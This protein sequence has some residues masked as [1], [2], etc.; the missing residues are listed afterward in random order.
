VSRSIP[1]VVVATRIYL[2]EPAAASFRLGAVVGRLA[3]EG[4]R[5]VVLTTRARGGAAPPRDEPGDV[6]R[7]PALRDRSGYVRGYL[8]YLSFDLPL[9]LRLLCSARPGVVL[10]EPPPT[11][12]AVVRVV[13]ALR[14]VPYVYFAPDIWSDAA[15]SAGAGRAVVRVLRAVERWVA[16][17]AARVV[18]VSDDLAARLR[19][20]APT[21]RVEVV[22]NGVDTAVFTLS[23][24]VAP[25]APDGAYAVYAGTT[26]EWQGAD[27]FLRAFAVVRERMPGARLVLVGQG[28]AWRELQRL[29]AEL[30][31]AGA[32]RFVDTR[33]APEAAAWLR[34]A[35]VSLVGI[36]PG[37]GY[38]FALPTKIGASLACGTPVLYA[39]PGPARE[40][41]ASAP[42]G[43]RAGESVDHDVDAVAD[44]LER[45]LEGEPGDRA[46]LA[47][48]AGTRVSLDAVAGR[49]VDVLR[50]VARPV[51]PV[52]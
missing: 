39:G 32:V 21:A 47:E 16:T 52:R 8:P 28:S 29:A 49:V 30:V 22:G 11:T 34:G 1:R 37:L 38:D 10:V 40:L 45:M 19:A 48:W 51:T 27:V 25:D 18:A 4:T 5:V 7:W 35:R 24:P 33:P 3:A 44:A 20:L 26:S 42:D 2:P 12:G 13:C 17:G 9:V 50:A 46:R 43:V 23:G 15:S 31:P 14:R 41:L 6:R 36:R